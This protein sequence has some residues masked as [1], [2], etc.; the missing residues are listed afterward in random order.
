MWYS[1]RNYNLHTINKGMYKKIKLLNVSYLLQL[2]CLNS[3][4]FILVC[5]LSSS[6]TYEEIVDLHWKQLDNN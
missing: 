5:N 6:S 4:A 2:D 3:D 1:Q